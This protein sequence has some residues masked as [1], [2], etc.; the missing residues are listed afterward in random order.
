MTKGAYTVTMLE[1][2]EKVVGP[3]LL[4]AVNDQQTRWAAT[5]MQP[6]AKVAMSSNVGSSGTKGG[7]FAKTPLI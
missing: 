1:C 2:V 4:V 7:N 5:N 6:K 3:R